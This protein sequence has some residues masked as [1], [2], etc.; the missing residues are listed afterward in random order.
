MAEYR[1]SKTERRARRRAEDPGFRKRAAARWA[2]SNALRDGRLVRGACESSGCAGKVEAHHEDYDKPLD[3]RWLCREHHDGATGSA[4]LRPL[5]KIKRE[6]KPVRATER[7]S[8][9][10]PVRLELVNGRFVRVD[11]GPA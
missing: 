5:D 7:E 2:V 4:G 9:Q 11:H 8:D 6:V 1:E 10:G 3:V